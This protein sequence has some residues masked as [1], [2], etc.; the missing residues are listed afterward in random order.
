M[1]FGPDEGLTRHQKNW[2][3]FRPVDGCTCHLLVQF[4]DRLSEHDWHYQEAIGVCKQAYIVGGGHVSLAVSKILA[5]LDLDITVIDERD[6]PDTFSNNHYAQRKLNIPYRDISAAIAEGDQV[7]VLTMTH[8]HKTDE[9]VAGLLADKRV[10]YLGVLG[11][12]KKI[13]Q[14]KTNLAPR[15]SV[16]SLQRIR[17]PIGLPI[18]SHTPA[19]IAVSIAAELIQIFNTP[20]SSQ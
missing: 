3:V 7:F 20:A 6:N 12:H 2:P 11:S 4:F 1:A 17:G 19:E 14:L 8:S 5:T 18:K 13:E 9:K 10:R 15:L 16:E